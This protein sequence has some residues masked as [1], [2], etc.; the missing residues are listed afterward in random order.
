MTSHAATDPHESRHAGGRLPMR[1]SKVYIVPDGRLNVSEFLLDTPGAAA[2]WG[3]DE[4]IPLPAA[5]LT[6]VHPTPDAD[7]QHL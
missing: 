4:P 7:P 3:D 1:R 2:P 6:Y 5:E